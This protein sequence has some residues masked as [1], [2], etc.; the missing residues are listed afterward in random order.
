MHIAVKK[1]RLAQRELAKTDLNLAA[2]NDLIT[3]V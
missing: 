2:L 3:L 1:T